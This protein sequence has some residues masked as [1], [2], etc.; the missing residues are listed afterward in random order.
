MSKSTK[1][2]TTETDVNKI[3]F[4]IQDLMQA[5]EN[6]HQEFEAPCQ[7][8][9]YQLLQ[10]CYE[11]YLKMKGKNKLIKVL[12]LVLAKKNVKIQSNTPTA[13]K[14]VRVVFNFSDRRKVS[15]YAK[16]MRWAEKKKILATELAA[17]IKSKGGIEAVCSINLDGSGPADMSAKAI[18]QL[19]NCRSIGKVAKSHAPAGNTD[20][21]VFFCGRCSKR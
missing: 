13:G 5:A 20:E 8:K 17:K 6:W 21:I 15:K 16:V 2:T 12:D 14:L 3:K 18:K 19:P 10:K 1:K 9:L 7:E 4:E 11:T